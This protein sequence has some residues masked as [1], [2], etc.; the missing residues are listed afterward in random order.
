MSSSNNSFGSLATLTGT[1]CG[2]RDP[3]FRRVNESMQLTIHK[4]ISLAIA[5]LLSFAEMAVAAY[6]P[7]FPTDQITP[8]QWRIYFDTV[9][10]FPD[11]KTFDNLAPN[12]IIVQTNEV[13][14]VYIF[15]AETHPAYPAFVRRWI[16]VD[17]NGD[18]SFMR[19][20]HYAGDKKAFANWW[21]EFDE[22]ERK[23][24]EQIRSRLGDSH[25]K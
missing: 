1:R 14:V 18:V 15:T 2:R 4:F 24:R 8:E 6:T 25:T 23:S 12:Q 17:K 16:D 20:S 13:D 22:L 3:Q 21:R 5:L 9:R 11:A 10:K 19:V 7:A